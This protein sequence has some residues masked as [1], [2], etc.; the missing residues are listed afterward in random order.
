M[1]DP[2]KK[3]LTRLA[4]GLRGHRRLAEAWPSAS[5]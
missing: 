1:R 4:L 3:L 5:R 2:M